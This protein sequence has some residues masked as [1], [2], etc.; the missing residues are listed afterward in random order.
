M[1]AKSFNG[2]YFHDLATGD[3]FMQ[4]VTMYK[5]RIYKDK[6]ETEA[7]FLING[8]TT[9]LNAYSYKCGTDEDGEYKEYVWFRLS[10]SLAKKIVS[11]DSVEV[12]IYENEF[13]FENTHKLAIRSLLSNKLPIEK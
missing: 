7:I 13:L 11:S 2:A 10:S 6:E 8:E 12:K 1:V 3:V 4:V 9:K 5:E